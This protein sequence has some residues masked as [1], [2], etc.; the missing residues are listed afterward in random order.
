MSSPTNPDSFVEALTPNAL[1][2][3][4]GDGSYEKVV[5]VP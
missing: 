2:D 1:G 3:V 4:F 5:K